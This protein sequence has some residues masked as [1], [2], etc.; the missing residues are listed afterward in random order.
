M[1]DP[2]LSLF[3][4][5]ETLL[6]PLPSSRRSSLD[7]F[8]PQ[9]A[10]ALED[11][12]PPEGNSNG[13]NG[14]VDVSDRLSNGNGHSTAPFEQIEHAERTDDIPFA[15][16]NGSVGNGMFETILEPLSNH[17]NG[18]SPIFAHS[19]DVLV[20]PESLPATA[21]SD[22]MPASNGEIDFE[23]NGAA[24]APVAESPEPVTASL[25]S[26]SQLDDPVGTRRNDSASTGLELPPHPASGSL[27][28]PYLVTEIRELRNRRVRRGLWR[29]IFG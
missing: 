17:V 15:H 18:T 3:S 23:N 22:H 12:T 11:L 25:D 6:M 5:P 13:D 28:T 19:G 27:F 8:L 9:F 10:T 21:E 2:S 20:S 4:H 1:G 26:E 24:V 7:S 14:H 16:Q 29:R